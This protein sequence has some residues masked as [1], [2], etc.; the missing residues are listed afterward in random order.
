MT[1]E[2]IPLRKVFRED[3]EKSLTHQGVRPQ[4]NPPSQRPAG[5]QTTQSPARAPHQQTSGSARDKK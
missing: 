4:G 1:D 2:Q 5:G 3:F